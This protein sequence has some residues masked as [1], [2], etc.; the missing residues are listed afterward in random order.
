MV[1]ERVGSNMRIIIQEP[2]MDRLISAY[3]LLQTEPGPKVFRELEELAELGSL[4]SMVYLG[5]AYQH[6]MG[7]EK[8]MSAAETWFRRGYDSGS[9]LAL[10]YLGHLYLAKK[11]YDNAE[12]VFVSGMKINYSPAIFCL[13]CMYLEGTGVIKQPDQA[14]ILFEKASGLGHVFAKRFLAKMYLSGRYG[15]FFF[16]KGVLLLVGAMKDFL[17]IAKSDPDSDLLRT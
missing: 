15:I 2:D 8:D 17:V 9:K 16:L 12:V 13:G 1:L 5:C 3:R 14:R 11:E 6:G 4:S 7:T 10:Y